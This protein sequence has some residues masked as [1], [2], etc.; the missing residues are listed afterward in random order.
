[1]FS[2]LDVLY[3]KLQKWRRGN[4]KAIDIIG[5]RSNTSELMI[6]EWEYPSKENRLTSEK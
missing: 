3:Y 2:L 6:G 5:S 1:M 4:Q